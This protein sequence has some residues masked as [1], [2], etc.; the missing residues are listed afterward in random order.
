[1]DEVTTRVR[2]RYTKLGK[3]RFTS[4]RDAARLW[5]RALRKTGLPVA[6]TQGFTPRPKISF[7]LALPTGGESLAEYLDVELL[8]DA[9]DVDAMP[10]QLTAALPDGFDV[11]ASQALLGRTVSLQDDV[12]S[13]TWELFAPWLTAEHHTLAAERLLAAS[14]L[15]IDRVRKG[16]RAC[17]DVRPA[18]VQLRTDRDR[19]VADL[20][21]V[22]RALRPAELAELAYPHCDPSSEPFAAVRALRTHQW[23]EHD[24]VRRE[25]ISL[26]TDVPAL[27][28]V[29]A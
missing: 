29:S 13:V 8:T 7:G 12:T 20:A 22:G 9:V 15:P 3:V 23:I 2:L 25:V 18:V 24:E 21:T 17:D 1:M 6:S 16:V 4:H 26:P 19:L 28:P 5:E 27:T 10:A 11:V 14:T